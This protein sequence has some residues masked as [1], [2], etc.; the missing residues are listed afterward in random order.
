MADARIL[1]STGRMIDPFNLTAEDLDIR[2]VAHSL[3]LSNR[4]SGHTREP[5]SV[6]EHSLQLTAYVEPRLKRAAFLHD[7]VEF[8]IGDM[9]RPVKKRNPEFCAIEHEIQ[10][11][12]F[13]LKGV[14]FEHLDELADF[15][16]RI[17][18][19]E[20]TQAMENGDQ[21]CPPG[22]PLG[23]TVLHLPWQ[24][25]RTE[26]IRMHDILFNQPQD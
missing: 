1:T 11:R 23:I 18:I 4:Y 20:M 21:F 13:A 15:D 16:T 3:S 8:A 6:A 12:I 7:W 9:A 2:A 10:Q 19:D 17:C 14:P 26:F 5:I 25:A 22:E 24:I